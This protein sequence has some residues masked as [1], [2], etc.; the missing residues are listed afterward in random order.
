[1]KIE[2]MRRTLIRRFSKNEGD[3]IHRCAT[4]ARWDGD[5]A[6]ETFRKHWEQAKNFETFL[7]AVRNDESLWYTSQAYGLM[8]KRLRWRTMPINPAYV[9]KT[10]HTIADGGSVRIGDLA[11]T[12]AMH[13]PNGYGDGETLVCV[14]GANGFNKASFDYIGSISGSFRIHETDFGPFRSD[15]TADLNGSYG[16]YSA[17]GIVVFERW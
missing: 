3:L 1:M 5:H 2:N 7:L 14:T 8:H 10:L 16:I 9:E 13:I 4:T 15:G 17:N 6:P 12:C 11:G